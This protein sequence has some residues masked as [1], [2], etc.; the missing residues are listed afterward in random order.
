MQQNL[1]EQ[2][3]AAM[4]ESV[5]RELRELLGITSEPLLTRIHRHPQAMPQY[6]VGHLDRMARIDAALAR[7][8]GLAVA[9]NAYRG[10]GIPDCVHSGE[11]A[12]EAVWVKIAVE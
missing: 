9:G 4:V 2:D 3:D 8:P 6:R 11:L 5:R 7:H 1:F 10:V 12:A